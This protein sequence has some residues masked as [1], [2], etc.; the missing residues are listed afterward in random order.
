MTWNEMMLSDEERAQIDAIRQR[1]GL[2][3]VDQALEW[4]AKTALRNGV[5]RVTGKGRTLY[6]VIG[7]SKSCV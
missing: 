1:E 2:E 6:A 5:K 7:N 4:L 3:S